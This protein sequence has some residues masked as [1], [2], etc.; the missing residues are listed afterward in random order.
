MWRRGT[1][2]V[3]DRH[4]DKTYPSL[5]EVAVVCG[6]SEVLLLKGLPIECDLTLSNTIC[7]LLTLESNRFL[8]GSAAHTHTYMY[9]T[10]Q[11]TTAVIPLA[12]KTAIGFIQA[13]VQAILLY[14]LC[15]ILGMIVRV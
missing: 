1:S 2:S 5:G 11:F 7:E 10:L 12:Y 8:G 3:T 14:S 15:V 6:R 9:T 13:E 4:T